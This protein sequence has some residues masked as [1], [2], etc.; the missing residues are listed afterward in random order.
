MLG[1]SLFVGRES[2]TFQE[3]GVRIN[4]SLE[5][6]S[7]TE[8]MIDDEILKGTRKLRSLEFCWLP[9]EIVEKYNSST[10]KEN[11]LV[12]D[13]YANCK[14]NCKGCYAKQ[15]DLF[16]SHNLVSPKRILNLIEE[17]VNNLGTKAVKYL[18]PTEFFRDKDVFYYLDRFRDMGVIF[19]VFVKD[20]M[21][22]SDVEAKKMFGHLG[23][24]TSRELV[25]RLASYRNLRILFN[26][27]SFDASITNDLVKGGYEG[28]EDYTVD[29]KMVQTKALQLFY[30]YFIVRELNEGREGRLLILNAP[31]VSETIDEAYKIYKYFVDRGVMVCSTVSMQSGCGGSL[32]KQKDD[33]FVRKLASYY[34]RVNHYAV[35]KGIISQEYFEKYGPSPYA[36][37]MHCMQMC[38]GVIIRET[39]QLMRCPGADH[40]EWV[41]K[42]T[43]T[44][45]LS[46]GI[47]NAWTKTR[48]YKQEL[49][50][51]IGCLAKPGIFTFDFKKEVIR[52][53]KELF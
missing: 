23:I 9:E 14:L 3:I 8:E 33:D 47:V 11:V 5:G 36:G 52:Q 29:Y 19:G 1:E 6:I 32:Y 25:R 45:L 27:R 22:G 24:T 50:V 31:I 26:F 42:I 28:K 34:A 16:K 43:P 17:S 10:N 7:L 4:S 41:D 18:G 38:S 44:E 49:K 13:V 30:E 2:A 37:A 15:P 12:Q 39:G 35:T 46:D 51:N 21:F 20:P 48:N 40:F 53:F